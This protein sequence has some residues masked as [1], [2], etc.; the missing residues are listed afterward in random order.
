MVFNSQASPLYFSKKDEL[1]RR[2]VTRM[3]YEGLVLFTDG[4]GKQAI[5]RWQQVLQLDPEN[6]DALA[7]L[8]MAG[9][10]EAL[11]E[12]QPCSGRVTL[13]LSWPTKPKGSPQARD[14]QRKIPSA[15][16]RQNRDSIGE[17]ELYEVLLDRARTAL[18]ADAWDFATALLKTCVHRRP[19]D[20]TAWQMLDRVQHRSTR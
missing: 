4:R 9:A 7:Y 5:V 19:S 13:R 15:R 6:A 20:K 8:E 11:R 14:R 16:G 17:G 18:N 1:L 2:F 10:S 12:T 3:L